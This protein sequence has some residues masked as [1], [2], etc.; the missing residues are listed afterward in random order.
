MTEERHLLRK[1][2]KRAARLFAFSR[3][4]AI[5]EPNACPSP[6]FIDEFNARGF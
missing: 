1:D 3:L 6:I 4:G 5:S 2:G